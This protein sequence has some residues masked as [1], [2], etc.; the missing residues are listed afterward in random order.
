MDIKEYIYVNNLPASIQN[1]GI[2]LI[3][4]GP[5]FWNNLFNLE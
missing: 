4:F 2:S 1:Y 5:I 3:M